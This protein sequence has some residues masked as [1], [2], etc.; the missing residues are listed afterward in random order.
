MYSNKRNFLLK[1]V[2]IGLVISIF[3]C[4][5]VAAEAKCELILLVRNLI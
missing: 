3:Y 4:I 2:R 5:I 1:K